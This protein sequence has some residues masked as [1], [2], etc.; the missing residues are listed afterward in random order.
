MGDGARSTILHTFI[1]HL[2]IA[3]ATLK[4][5]E[6]TETKKAIELRGVNPLMTREKL[7]FPIVEKAVAVTH[8][9]YFQQG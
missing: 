7:A 6:W 8:L 2:C 5:I 1:C 4:E 3:A 9:F